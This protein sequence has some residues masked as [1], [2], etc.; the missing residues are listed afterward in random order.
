MGC[1]KLLGFVSTYKTVKFAEIRSLRLGCLHHSLLFIIFVCASCRKPP[2]AAASRPPPQL[3]HSTHPP[4]ADIVVVQVVQQHGYIKLTA[5]VGSVRMQLQ[6]ATQAFDAATGLPCSL[7]AGGGGGGGGGGSGGGSG[8]SSTCYPCDPNYPGCNH[9]YDPAGKLPYCRSDT[10]GR[11]S[12]AHCGAVGGQCE[13]TYWDALNMYP[14]TASSPFFVT[15]RFMQSYEARN[16]GCAY[17]SD[18]CFDAYVLNTISGA[19]TTL[20]ECKARGAAASTRVWTPRGMETQ[21]IV[22]K[23]TATES[24]LGQC[25]GT[26]AAAAHCNGGVTAAECEA[27]CGANRYQG[28]CVDDKVDDPVPAPNRTNCWHQHNYYVGSV[29]RYTLQL[30]HDVVVPGAPSLAA[31]SGEME[32]TLLA[33]DGTLVTPGQTRER[34]DFFTVGALL[35]AA[36]HGGTGACGV[37]LDA[38]SLNPGSTKSARYDGIELLISIKLA[39]TRPW[40]GQVD[41]SY[42]Y[43]V[44]A[45]YGSK[46]KVSQ[47]IWTGNSTD[48]R[49]IR[50]A[51]G[52]RFNVV[53]TGEM[54]APDTMTLLLQLTT[55]IALLALATTITDQVAITFMPRKSEYRSAKYDAVTLAG[56]EADSM[57]SLLLSHHGG[58]GGMKAGA[59]AGQ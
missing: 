9:T 7:D 51:H 56:D 8:S 52:L 35:A 5:P 13:C 17:H 42:Q 11:G 49:T 31:N 33:C 58:G 37:D 34:Q 12:L 57:H 38:L 53:F 20:E 59:G 45:V 3:T 18:H 30:A 6:G 40:V 39:N 24:K 47:T 16:P 25:S 55:S 46:S 19:N 36:T 21:D 10:A 22:C 44:E 54:G 1:A 26:G 4:A 32:G 29:E 27:R 23:S 2:P 14:V 43:S 28:G 48:T 15:T 41:A 50:D